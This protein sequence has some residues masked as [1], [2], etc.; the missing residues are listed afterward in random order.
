MSDSPS[1]KW[2]S[3][4]F[5]LFKSNDISPELIAEKVVDELT[6]KWLDRSG[7]KYERT[8]VVRFLDEIGEGK[9]FCCYV[10]SKMLEMFLINATL[11]VEAKK[12]VK[13]NV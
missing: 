2:C 3:E 1:M 9:P 6:D 4:H 11:A 8:F 13:D 12:A 10:G 5:D 7:V